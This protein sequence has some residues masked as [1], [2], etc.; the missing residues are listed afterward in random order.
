MSNWLDSTGLASQTRIG[1]AARGAGTQLGAAAAQIG[2]ADTQLGTAGAELWSA[3]QWWA[4]QL[5]FWLCLSAI[6]FL[7]LTVWYATVEWPHVLHTLLQ[8]LLGLLF[9]WPL[10]RILNAIGEPRT[11]A[12]VLT[13]F[14]ALAGTAL[15]W[16]LLRMV[17]FTW[18]TGITGLWADFG[19]WYFGAIFI[20]LCWAGLHYVTHYHR[21][22]Q[23]EH[24]KV[25]LASARSLQA[26]ALA[27]E[28]QLKM[29]RYQLN[30]HFLFNTLNAVSALVRLGN[31]QGCQETIAK[32]GLL[33]R[34]SLDADPLEMVPLEKEMEVLELYLD[35]EKMRFAER[36]RVEVEIDAAALEALVPGFFL[37][38]LVENAIQHAIAPREE[39]GFL[40]VKARVA[41][42]WLCLE[43]ADSGA[44]LVAA[45][46]QNGGGVG[47][48]NTVERL[49]AL[50]PNRYQL[51]FGSPGDGFA[52]RVCFPFE[53]AA[54]RPA[55]TGASA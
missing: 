6:T 22:L 18:M 55:P 38:P 41:D 46:L 21:L 45:D 13:A 50:Y 30:P 51:D 10:H 11:L 28:A 16:T 42:G 8:G 25:M 54:S 29:L 52:V 37:Q 43:V 27:K 39:G 36:L 4:V 48:S 2:V 20:F 53:T 26:E 24:G 44:G 15:L 3:R 35:I 34:R 49:E 31:A 33:L 12:R 40:G 1:P 32:L 14:A 9:S 7:T 5:F 23:A 47:L 17:T 19:G